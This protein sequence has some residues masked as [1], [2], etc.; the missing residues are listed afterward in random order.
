M[1]FEG[2]GGRMNYRIWRGSDDI[3]AVMVFLHGLGQCSA[4][5]HRYARAMN[6]SGI[7]VWGLDH[8]GHGLSEG[9]P[10]PLPQ[11]PMLVANAELFLNMAAADHPGVPL[12]LAGHSL[13]AGVSL[14]AMD[15]F[16]PAVQQV[17]GVALT[18]TPTLDVVMRLSPPAVPT[19]LL[20]GDDDRIAAI[21]P[22]Q[23][24]AARDSRAEFRVFHGAGHDLLHEPVHRQVQKS[25]VEFVHQRIVCPPSR[26]HHRSA[27]AGPAVGDAGSAN[28]YPGG[29]GRAIR[30]A[31][32]RS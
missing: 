26:L 27:A 12:V 32:R 4:N 22:V 11:L 29:S 18:G 7:E 15:R 2:I 3:Q 6:R 17:R 8:I 28:A 9:D 25:I 21:G 31:I 14:L 19:L 20:H 1:F 5:Y 30:A 13:G 23:H 16:G 10:D 24:W